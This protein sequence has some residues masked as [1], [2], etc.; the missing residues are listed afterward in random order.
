MEIQKKLNVLFIC[1]DFP[2]LNTGGSRRAFRF[3]KELIKQGVNPIVI[4]PQLDDHYATKFDPSLIEA[5]E[6]TSIEVVRVPLAAH[7]RYWIKFGHK[8][9][10][11]LFDNVYRR[12]KM[13]LLPTVEGLIQERNIQEVFVSVPPFS[14]TEV[15][16]FLK[17]LG[18]RVIVDFRDAWSQWVI[19]P[20]F[21]RINFELV[22]RNEGKVLRQADLIS[23]VTDQ[24]K[25]DWLQLHKIPEDKVQVIPNSFEGSVA[26][27]PETL[28]IESEQVKIVYVGSF[29]YNERSHEM[30][31]RNWWEKPVHQMLQY[32]PRKE[33]W[34][35]RSP[36][37]FFRALHA[38]FERYPD[39]QDKVVVEIAGKIPVW[40]PKQI[41]E[42]NLHKQV[43]LL[44]FI[45]ASASIALQKSADA[46]LITS[47][48]IEGGRDYCIAGKTFEYVEVQRPIL[49]FVAEGS[50]KDF[51]LAAGN[52]V[53]CNPDDLEDSVDKL[54]QFFQGQLTLR[55][56]VEYM[57]Q[58]SSAFTG[59]RLAEMI[60]SLHSNS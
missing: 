56:N 53:V 14:V 48:K 36:Y 24:I 9:I 23:T 17:S 8:L 34:F 35:Y 1:Y 43:R 4:A 54:F 31:M 26:H 18:V 21:T 16:P 5:L 57:E 46:L 2:P 32:V 6:K 60:L 28:R 39:Y 50:Q 27:F 52:A 51:L 45:D 29:Y 55:P 38:F 33:N 25:K 22:F 41:E 49:G 19:A 7:S 47:M 37:F 59:Y 30:I 3:C 13:H 10:L 40:L 44:G 58:Y 11:N 20:Y 15:L 42:Y 12:W